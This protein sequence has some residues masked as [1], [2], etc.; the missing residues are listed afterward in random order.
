MF[1]SNNTIYY[2]FSTSAQ[3]LASVAGISAALVVFRYQGL[4]SERSRLSDDILMDIFSRWPSFWS[5]VGDS[6]AATYRLAINN[7][8]R[9]ACLAVLVALHK[10]R[11]EKIVLEERDSNIKYYSNIFIVKFEKWNQITA[12]ACKVRA[13]V[14]RSSAFGLSLITGA[15][16]LTLKPDV[17][18]VQGNAWP[19]ILIFLFLMIIYFVFIFFLT[20]EC[21]QRP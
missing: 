16:A 9:I 20:L 8:D 2:F 6:A 19:C 15:I 12:M 7:D 5:D 11:I 21:F 14:M 18:A 4:L 3:T 17:A 10:T 13:L 1:P